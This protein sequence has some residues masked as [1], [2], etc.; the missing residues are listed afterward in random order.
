MTKEDYAAGLDPQLD[1]AVKALIESL[2]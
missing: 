2:K 1:A